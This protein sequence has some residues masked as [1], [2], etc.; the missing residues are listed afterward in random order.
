[1][2]ATLSAN[3]SLHFPWNLQHLQPKYKPVMREIQDLMLYINN[4]MDIMRQEQT[5]G[6]KFCKF[7]HYQSLSDGDP[8]KLLMEN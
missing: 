2:L 4:F 6:K 8:C 5:S 7:W 1:M 3:R